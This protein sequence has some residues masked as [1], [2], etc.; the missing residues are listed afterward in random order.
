MVC[1]LSESLARNPCERHEATHDAGSWLSGL[2]PLHTLAGALPMFSMMS[3]IRMK[4]FISTAYNPSL[5]RTASPAVKE[6]AIGGPGRVVY[7]RFNDPIS[8]SAMVLTSILHIVFAV[9]QCN[10]VAFLGSAGTVY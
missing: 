3:N 6:L 1:S 8:P 2:L 5:Q 7:H 4:V 10:T 9:R